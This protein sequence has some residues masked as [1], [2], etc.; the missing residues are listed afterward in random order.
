MSKRIGKFL[1]HFACLVVL[2]TAPAIAAETEVQSS[3][4]LID[5]IKLT[6]AQR[7]LFDAAIA[8]ARARFE[9]PSADR[10]ALRKLIIEMDEPL[11]EVLE[12]AQW[13]AYLR[14]KQALVGELL[15]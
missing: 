9:A 3:A 2:V 15:P 13:G 7:P 6:E 11:K 12:Q 10:M 8:D 4:E 1:T 5:E 14:Y